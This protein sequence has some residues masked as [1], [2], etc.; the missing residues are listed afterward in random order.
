MIYFIVFF[1]LLFCVIRY[2]VYEK[3][4]Y[5]KFHYIALFVLFSLIAGLRWRLGVDT[6]KYMN[7]FQY[8]MVSLTQLNLKYIIESRYQ[9]FWVLLNAFCKSFD[10]FV[11]LQLLVSAFFQ[12]AIFYFLYHAC[13][14]PFTALIIYYMYNYLYFSMEIMRESL[15]IACFLYGILGLNKNAIAKYYIWATCA[16]MFHFFAAFLFLIPVLLS[17][18]VP[19]KRKIIFAIATMLIYFVL[20]ESILNYIIN[21]A[22]SAISWKLANYLLTERYSSNLWRLTG[23]LY[24]LF[25]LLIITKTLL[26]SFTFLSP[27]VVVKSPKSDSAF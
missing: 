17:K 13:K 20:K 19:L 1:Y 7:D 27:G 9:P 16:F 24:N 26:P 5:F 8:E 6:V 23:L 12:S 25:P 15:A 10:S 14:K 4:R 2:D 18:C 22:P 21:I 3:Q 11:L